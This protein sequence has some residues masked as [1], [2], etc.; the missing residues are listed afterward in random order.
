MLVAMLVSSVKHDAVT[1]LP[2]V[3]VVTTETGG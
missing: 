3:S 1:L 2:H